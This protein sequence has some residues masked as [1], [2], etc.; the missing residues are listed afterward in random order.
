MGEA[1]MEDEPDNRQSAYHV[2]KIAASD[3]V[4]K[5]LFE[6]VR[7]YLHEDLGQSEQRA[8][9]RAQDELN[10]K[11]PRT[12]LD[13][14]TNVGIAIQGKTV[15]DLGAGLGGMS[16][17]LVL[18]GANVVA[19]EPGGAWADLAARRV[20]RHAGS[21]RLLRAFGESIPLPDASVD[22]IVSWRVLEHVRD[23][24][25]VLSE[26]WRVLRP[27]GRFFLTCE[28][29]LAFREAHYDV[30]WLPL[31]PKVLGA[32]YLRMLG[33]SPAFLKE[34][35]T[36]TT[37]PQVLRDCRRLGFVRSR[38]EQV[39]A[40]LR[41]KVGPKWSALR[42]L[43]RWTNGKGPLALERASRTFRFGVDELF[44]KPG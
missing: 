7:Q 14:L 33:R 29:Y 30:P 11:I 25:Q 22:L 3:S 39:A 6:A 28:N 2:R 43:G 12:A 10:R 4:D 27:G 19:L 24:L 9:D 23:P 40:S 36:Y 38:D 42:L 15:L 13:Y 41:S 1:S 20:G 16:E 31:L 34:A 17:E 26:A 37:Y 35:V 44:Y 32:I 18:R 8:A 21:F 5:D